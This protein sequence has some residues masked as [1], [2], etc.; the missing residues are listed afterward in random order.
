MPNKT[1]SSE[2]AEVTGINIRENK[3][4]VKTG[5]YEE[6]VPTCTP[7]DGLMSFLY[8]LKKQEKPCIL[9]A[10]NGF[11]F[12]TPR[13][14][15]LSTDL[16]L[17]EEFQVFVKGF[18]D[19]L[20][21]FKK[22]LKDRKKLK[23]S[24]NQTALVSDFLDS[25]DILEAH[26]ALN[27]V[28]MLKKLMEKL[29]K[30][31]SVIYDNTRTVDFIINA[32]KRAEMTKKIKFSLSHLKNVS[33]NM[34]NKIAK[35][36]ISMNILQNA[37]STGGIAGLSILLGESIDNKPR[38]TNNKKIIKAIFNNIVKSNFGFNS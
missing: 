22:I 27:D 25:T 4:F 2:A 34:K 31:K 32:K 8:F 36:G 21:I 28:I 16:R 3:M 38:V 18:S 7:R 12:D 11:R 24:F 35:A 33:Q 14:I 26:N 9:L 1:M 37:C 29:C 15:K 5:D 19:S 6:E 30:D 10:H 23:L 13:M 20:Y 17:F